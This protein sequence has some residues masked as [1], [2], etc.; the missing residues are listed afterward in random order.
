MN[1]SREVRQADYLPVNM[2]NH[3]APM[4]WG[5]IGLIAIEATIFIAFVV[6]F[7]FLRQYSAEWPMGG[8]RPPGL[9]LPTTGM[10]LLL[11]SA[12]SIYWGD[13]RSRMGSLRSMQVGLV[14]GIALVSAFFALKIYEYGHIGYSWDTNAYTS[15]VF[16]ITGFFLIHVAA[17]VFG[18]AVLLTASLRGHFNRQRT[19][20]IR[21]FSLLWFFVVLGWLPLYFTVYLSHYLFGVKTG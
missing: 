4:W 8:I 17:L 1:G 19:L 13:H 12:V 5:A 18:A 10:A 7:F 21:V 6:S 16:G 11:L 2:N 9:V 15:V 14:A 3:R 20:G